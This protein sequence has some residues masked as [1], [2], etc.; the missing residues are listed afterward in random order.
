MALIKNSNK[1]GLNFLVVGIVVWWSGLAGRELYMVPVLLGLLIMAF[2]GCRTN[3][4]KQIFL[5]LEF[6]YFE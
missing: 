6:M 3:S 4:F 2:Q 5:W 1:V